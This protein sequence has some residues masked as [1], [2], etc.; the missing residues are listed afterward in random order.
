MPLYTPESLDTLRQRID[1]VEVLSSHVDL[2]RAGATYKGLCPFHDE[3]SPS[4][5]VKVGDSHYH[6]FGCG[7]HGDAIAFLMDYLKLG[8]GEAVESL[9]ERFNVVLERL[10]GGESAGP[11]RRLMREALSLANRFFQCALL[12]SAEGQEALKYLFKRGVDLD[13]IRLCQIGYAPNDGQLLRRYLHSK[14]I[15]DEIQKEVGLLSKEHKRPFFRQRI[16]FPIHSPQGGVI[17][18][19]ARKYREDTFGGKYINTP[20]TPLFKKSRVLFGLNYGR[21]R[22]AKERWAI[23]VEGQIDALRLIHTGLNCTVAAQGTAFGEGHV[24]ELVSLGVNRVYLAMDADEAGSEAACKVGHLF[25]RAGIDVLRVPLPLGS[26]P[27]TLI[28]EEGP[29]HFRKLL[30]ISEPY[31]KFLYEHKMRHVDPQSPAAK[32]QV[33]KEI[34]QGVRSW[35]SPVMVHEALKKLS[36]MANVPQETLGVGA[37]LSPNVL[38]K[39]KE[40]VGTVSIN[41]DRILEGDLLRWLLLCGE[42]N[43]AF[44]NL[45]KEHLKKEDLRESLC[46]E[47]YS[48]YLANYEAGDPCDPLSL[49]SRSQNPQLQDLISELLTKKVNKDRADEQL[50][51]TV[52]KLLDRNRMVKCEE[53]KAKIHSGNL[54][55]EELM[56]L[57]AEFTKLRSEAPEV[58]LGD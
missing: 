1:L 54:S 41:P 47:L 28:L 16:T 33:L 10:E 50:V 52:Q 46:A 11:S 49:L 58:K 30:D 35:E 32:S 27:D 19:S 36:K 9:A 29:E 25:Q 48:I 57:A 23:V 17:A 53:I 5:V 31:L 12:H 18:F 44:V 6:C 20:E 15:S 34:C 14:K 2:K 56:T 8:F 24:Q 42:E 3:R 21:R 37:E 4:F 7:A 45:V 40:R 39:Q 43:A 55:E 13:F 26:D 51:E 38:I 22:I